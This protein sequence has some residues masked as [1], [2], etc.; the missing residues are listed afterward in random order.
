MGAT[1]LKRAL[2]RL[3]GR[4]G[5]SAGSLARTTAR[6]THTHTDPRLAP[7][8]FPPTR[9]SHTQITPPP[10]PTPITPAAITTIVRPLVRSHGADT[11]AHASVVSPEFRH[12]IVPGVGS[13]A[14]AI[15]TGAGRRVPMALGDPLAPL[16]AWPTLVDAFLADIVEAD[17]GLPRQHATFWHASPVY[18]EWL[19]SRYPLFRADAF[20]A[21]TRL[22][23]TAWT[24]TTR[25][26]TLRRDARQARDAGVV[27]YEV[28]DEDLD[29]PGARA[30]LAS[31]SAAW[32]AGKAVSDRPLRAFCRTPDWASLRLGNDQGGRLFV[33]VV[34]PS[35]AKGVE[36]EKPPIS[37]ASLAGVVLLDPL[38]S[39]GSVTGYFPTL[40]QMAPWAHQG[41]LKAA[42]E[43]VLAAL[44]TETGVKTL[45]L[46]FAP[47]FASHAAS[48]RLP[49][50]RPTGF[51]PP[52]T[53]AAYTYG[54]ALYAFTAL[55]AS[56]T[57]W[58]GASF[59]GRAGAFGASAG[60]SLAH[61]YIVHGHTRL[62][63]LAAVDLAL[64]LRWLGFWDTL[65]GAVAQ[66]AG[67][68]L[69]RWVVALGAATEEAVAPPPAAPTTTKPAPLARA[70]PL[71]VLDA[72][73]SRPTTPHEGPPFVLVSAAVS[74]AAALS[75]FAAAAGASPRAGKR[76]THLPVSPTSSLCPA[77]SIESAASGDSSGARTPPAGARSPP[78]APG[79]P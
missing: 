22:D 21:E 43:A 73:P 79:T 68:A 53:A 42:Y 18:A 28:S 58:A 32:R 33:A 74:A 5:G 59:D 7:P 61:A 20:G 1:Q 27:V 6:N 63:P 56:K 46:G 19:A 34:K 4:V 10:T 50:A 48:A 40:N 47:A 9:R 14:F 52:L 15:A 35:G 36:A 26:R 66:V 49:T 11:L 65:A 78:L 41:T 37:A 3:G 64:C 38:W 24:H 12:Y 67:V 8:C 71:S 23:V 69:P 39:E 13:I 75:P 54:N 17:C 72:P 77:A 31:L 29:A 44:K 2:H 57:R 76:A 30:A 60:A 25:T 70:S 51:A 55:A 62:T 45:N 16:S